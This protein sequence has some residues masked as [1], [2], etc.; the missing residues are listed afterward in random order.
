MRFSLGAEG[1][2]ALAVECDLCDAWRIVDPLTYDFDVR[3]DA[4]WQPADGLPQRAVTP[5]DVVFSLERLRTAGLPH[6][7]LLAAVDGIVPYGERTVRLTLHY[8]DPDL[9]L[10]LASPYAVIVNPDALDGVDARTGRVVGAGPW[11]FERKASG[12][13]TLT[14]WEGAHTPTGVERI[15]FSIVS[16]NDLAARLLRQGRA[17]AAHVPNAL[18][19]ELEAEGLRSAVVER[20]GRGVLLGLNAR[21]P[22]F[23]DDGLRRAVLAALDL[24]AAIDATFGMGSPGAGLPLLDDTWRL[25]EGEL[26]ALLRGGAGSASGAPPFTL[27][28]AN[29]GETHA[30]HGELLAGQLRDAGFDVEV[31]LATRAEYLRRVWQERDFDAF[32]GPMPPTDTPN[33]FLLGFAHSE[34]A[35]NVTGGD[36]EL[37]ALIERFAVELDPAARAELAREA[38][39]RIVEGARFVL[40]APLAERWAFSERVLGFTA[41]VPMGAGD[42]WTRVRLAPPEGGA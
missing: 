28:V 12:Q 25:G 9:P 38:Q 4:L 15:E 6:A 2:P 33:A 5:Q 13:A 26:D 31:E 10:A 37:D 40:A 1:A 39:R 30:A 29:F 20:Q 11:L 23:D 8:P 7:P 32:A 18:W 21:R 19:P 17:D 34:G 42:L 35:A 3:R 22:P 24:Q 41:D 27:L 16:R 36:P 14:A